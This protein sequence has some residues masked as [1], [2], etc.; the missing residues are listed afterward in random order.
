MVH[1]WR[2][3][4]QLTGERAEALIAITTEQGFSG[5]A[6]GAFGNLGWALVQ[7]NQPEDGIRQILRGIEANIEQGHTLDYQLPLLADAYCKMGRAETALAIL[8]DATN[9]LNKTGTRYFEAEL[10]RLQ[11][12]LLLKQNATRCGDEEL[13]GLYHIG[14]HKD[15]VRGS[16]QRH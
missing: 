6:A 10:Y 2:R 1:Q 3:E 4:P 5:L 13:L 11:G 9:L 12:E 15:F 14:P 16:H 8:I 7:Q